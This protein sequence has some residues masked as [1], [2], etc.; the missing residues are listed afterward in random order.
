[1]TTKTTQRST[2]I[3]D[4]E[5]RG[6]RTSGAGRRLAEEIARTEIGPRP[7]PA[8]EATRARPAP[9]SAQIVTDGGL[10]ITAVRAAS[11]PMVEVRLRIPFA[12][13]TA[14]A[15][16]H[17]ACA[18]LL[19][20]SILLGTANRDRERIDAELAAVGGHLS[21]QVGPQ[22]LLLSGSVLA[23]G[24]PV[25]LEILADTLTA[26][27]YRAGDVLR[28]RDKLVEHLA[29][30]AAQPSAIA[31]AHLQRRRFGAHPAALEVPDADSVAAVG[32]AA[33]RRLHRNA[34]L[35]A[36]SALILVGDLKA[37]PAAKSAAQILSRWVDA[38]L[39]R[40]LSTPPVVTGGSI[41]A[42]HRPGAVQTQTR[43]TAQGVLRTD[44]DYAAAQLANIVFGGYFSSRL[45]ENLREDKGF[46]YHAHS[47]L[48]FW[49][50]RSAVT[51][52]YDTATDVA[53]AALVETRHELGRIATTAPTTAEIESARNYAIGSLAASLATQAGYASMLTTLIGSGLDASWLAR[54]QKNLAGVS[55]AA[56]A[57]AAQR[58]FAPSAITGVVVGDIE[59]DA[60]VWARLGGIELASMTGH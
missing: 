48:E 31:R 8:L 34:V 17:A 9:R 49:P 52:S 55:E 15:G 47:A 6:Q 59:S 21:A 37:G 24:L 46:T 41:I 2:G 57:A 38:R 14:R 51:I 13:P 54:H 10:A 18:E 5:Q 26:A 58:I 23:P 32:V 29:I 50:G 12:G 33:V 20:E 19:A 53:A 27:T 42:H 56:V 44:P 16:A 43:L 39:A 60:A 40:E 22:R 35:P 3:R 11:T 30:S 28:E 36:G 1:M 4:A 45:V 25:L 7:L